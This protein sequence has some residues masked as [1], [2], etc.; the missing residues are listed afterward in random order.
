MTLKSL[1]TS[2]LEDKQNYSRK[3]NNKRYLFLRDLRDTTHLEGIIFRAGG[4]DDEDISFCKVEK[5][6]IRTQEG[7]KVVKKGQAIAQA[8]LRKTED[9]FNSLERR[10]IIRRSTSD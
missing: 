4:R 2:D 9:Y 10:K 6:S 5:C 7:K 8:L 1:R 3:K